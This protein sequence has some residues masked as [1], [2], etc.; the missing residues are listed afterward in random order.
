M[1]SR[2]EETPYKRTVRR[3]VKE[4]RARVKV[5]VGGGRKEKHETRLIPYTGQGDRRGSETDKATIACIGR[6]RV[7]KVCNEGLDGQL[8]LCGIASL[9]ILADDPVW[10]AGL[11]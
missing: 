2:C 4:I 1:L 11:D 7:D 6:D 8:D 10:N 3:K 9:D 5:L